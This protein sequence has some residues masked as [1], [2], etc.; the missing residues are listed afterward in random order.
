MASGDPSHTER[1]F[2]AGSVVRS[3]YCT[4]VQQLSVTEGTTMFALIAFGVFI[5]LLAA[6]L[7]LPYPQTWHQRWEPRR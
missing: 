4:R 7:G 2:P 6:V 1:S 5:L 3:G